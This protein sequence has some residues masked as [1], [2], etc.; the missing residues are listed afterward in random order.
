[1]E[2]GKEEVT[3]RGMT[4]KK[5]KMERDNGQTGHTKLK[6]LRRKEKVLREKD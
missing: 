5:V 4:D 3:I 2:G 1:M 6:A